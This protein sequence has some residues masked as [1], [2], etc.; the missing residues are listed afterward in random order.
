MRTQHSWFD[1]FL[2][3]LG[4]GGD[5]PWR[6]FLL[7]LGLA[8]L[9]AMAAYWAVRRV[10][11]ELRGYADRGRTAY[12][13]ARSRLEGRE[14]D[15]TRV[16]QVIDPGFDLDAFKRQC[17]Q[18]FAG[19][20]PSQNAD[21]RALHLIDARDEPGRQSATLRFEGMLRAPS[22]PPTPFDEEWVFTRPTSSKGP[23]GDWNPTQER[24]VP[25]KAG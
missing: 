6:A 8:A 10:R 5:H 14:S 12:H 1:S 18:D 20:H 11:R 23:E 19:T 3:F 22:Q 13:R 9:A 2:I 4:F 24:A 16:L 15:L 7:L 21:I 17:S 25:R